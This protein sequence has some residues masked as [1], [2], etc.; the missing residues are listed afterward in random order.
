MVLSK[1]LIGPVIIA[2]IVGF[3]VGTN[4]SMG[5]NNNIHCQPCWGTE[6]ASRDDDARLLKVAHT[7]A[8]QALSSVKR[9]EQPNP[10]A[11]DAGPYQWSRV[12]P[13]VVKPSP[14][15][16]AC[17]L[18][19]PKPRADDVPPVVVKS[20]PICPTCPLMKGGEG[21][22]YE[23]PL[24]DA[25]QISQ[26]KHLFAQLPNKTLNF[27]QD[28]MIAL[29]DKLKPYAPEYM[30]HHERN[31]MYY[32]RE[33][34]TLYTM[35]R[36]FK[37][38]IMI[39]IGSGYSSNV[40][41]RALGKNAEEAGASSRAKHIIIE[42]FRSEVVNKETWSLAEVLVKK[43]QD[44]PMSVYEQLG[45]N[46]MLFID[47]SHVMQP[48]GD[49]ILELLFILP[50]LK[51]GVWVHIHDIYLPYD[52]RGGETS[53]GPWV[54]KEHY[55]EQW[56]L[57]AFLYENRKWEI[58]WSPIY[59]ENFVKLDFFRGGFGGGIQD[60]SGMYIRRIAD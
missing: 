19:Q 55:T 46:D 12:P 17:P 14:T 37:P 16:P 22:S 6:I 23:N 24:P 4:M 27:Q 40:A 9:E 58:I 15:C 34:T 7:A 36:H 47:S 3:I 5:S 60:S 1:M 42:P 29:Y 38:K 31:G 2:F 28:K 33:A 44:V 50:R 11:D 26:Y 41:G 54:G 51:K 35:L 21:M 45:E 30:P 8:A 32:K 25:T 59:L 43:V 10:R 39:E 18:E 52:Y 48:Y 13:V 56:T 53:S 57:A 20:C 49:T